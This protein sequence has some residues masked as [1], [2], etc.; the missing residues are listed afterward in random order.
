MSEPRTAVEW[1]V[2]DLKRR[3]VEWI[4]TLCGHGL[5]PLFEAAARQQIRL[6]DTRNEQT[7]AYIADSFGRLTGRPGVCAVSSGVAVANALSG[8]VNAWFDGAPMLLISGSAALRT[9]GMGHFQDLDQVALASPVS[10]FSRQID[11][12]DRVLSVLDSAWQA[13]AAPEPGP[14][15]VMFPMDVQTAET[16]PLP[17]RAPPAALPRCADHSRIALELNRAQS[18]L[19]VAGSGMHYASAGNA[20]MHFSER[21]AVPIVTPI[22]DRGCIDRPIAGFLGVI[23]AASGG[24]ALLAQSDCL[25]LA[26]AS[27]DYRLGYLQPEA[28][29]PDAAILRMDAHWSDLEEACARCG[30]KRHHGWLD[31]AR[32]QRD[33][34]RNG[35]KQRA[36]E[37]AG[38]SLHAIHIID[39]IRAAAPADTVLL[40]DAGSVGQWAHQLLCDRYPGY[41]LT[42]GRSGVV[43]WGI[44]GAMAARLA[45]PH[46]PVLLL[47]G[48]GAFTFNV[49]DLECAVRQGL[50]FVAVVADDQAWGITRAGH[51][52]QF[53][54]ALSSSL[55]PIAFDRLAESLGCRSVRAQSPEEI[56]RAVSDALSKPE[57]TVIHAPII[58]GTP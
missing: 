50:P 23:G 22:W 3:G 32:R 46:R 44:G 34:F 49:A 45:Y 5:D 29:R 19:I 56:G 7:A 54:Q 43:G 17:W 53:G 35:V 15:H 30:G 51:I 9:A 1:L 28:V 37:Q 40:I 12:P 8:V 20:L 26:G 13:A 27:V 36:A 42:C 10:K 6:I 14:A 58:G 11:S 4:A 18:P 25:L 38:R 47:C 57:V 2:S 39:G 33:D 24:P 48:D 16:V 52:R 31:A 41:W 21:F 55:G